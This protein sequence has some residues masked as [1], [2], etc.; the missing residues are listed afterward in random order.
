MPASPF[1]GMC[2][3]AHISSMHLSLG[4]SIAFYGCV[5]HLSRSPKSDRLDLRHM[6]SHNTFGLSGL[7][8]VVSTVVRQIPGRTMLGARLVRRAL[9]G[10]ERAP[11]THGRPS[12]R[13]RSGLCGQAVKR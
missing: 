13:A 3:S 9:A 8:D 11:E 4:V 12:S 7:A 2:C 5:S 1:R 10:G 6:L